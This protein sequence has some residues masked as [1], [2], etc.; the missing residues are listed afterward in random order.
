[1]ERNHDLE[2]T[3]K[4]HRFGYWNLCKRLPNF[5]NMAALIT[6]QSVLSKYL[7]DSRIVLA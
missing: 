6:V 3:C 5:V 4:Q 2:V 7:R 1:M